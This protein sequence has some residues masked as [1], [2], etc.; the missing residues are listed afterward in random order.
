MVEF[1]GWNINDEQ[2]HEFQ[3]LWDEI[4]MT[5]RCAYIPDPEDEV[6][7][8]LAKEIADDIDNEVLEYVIDAA[9]TEVRFDNAMKVVE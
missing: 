9:E 4:N 1:R 8:R 2:A 5:I 6:I 3:R 7:A